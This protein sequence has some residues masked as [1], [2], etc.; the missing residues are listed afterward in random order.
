LKK[1][2]IFLKSRNDQHLSEFAKDVAIKKEKETA[3]RLHLQEQK[4]KAENHMNGMA[5]LSAQEQVD[6]VTC[7]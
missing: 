2:D 4:S 3:E 7:N 5:L 1:L 6:L